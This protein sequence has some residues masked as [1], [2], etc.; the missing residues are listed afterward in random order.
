VISQWLDV[1]ARVPSNVDSKQVLALV[2]TLLMLGSTL[3]YA[4]LW[5]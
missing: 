5:I 3:A 2:L 1:A 4:L